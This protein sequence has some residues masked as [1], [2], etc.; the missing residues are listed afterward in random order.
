[1]VRNFS[2][3]FLLF[4]LAAAVAGC[5]E[6]QKLLKSKD[7]QRMYDK[8][9]EYYEAGKYQKSAQLLQDVAPYFIGTM[10]GDS[11][12]YYMAASYYKSG[13]FETSAMLLDE[14]RHT[15]GSSPFL[16]DAE[17]MYAKG[18]YYLSPS[19]NRDQAATRRALIAIDEYMERYPNSVKREVLE[20]DIAELQQKLYD[21]AYINA[22]TYYKIGRYKAAVVALKNALNQ[23]PDSNHREEIMYLITKSNYLL[24]HNSI[25]S[26]QRD[27]YLDM[28][29]NY[30]NFVSEFPDSK[31]IKELDKMQETAKDY[32]ANYQN[33]D[34]DEDMDDLNDILNRLNVD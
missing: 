17:Y 33:I 23:F 5:S 15:Y 12:A 22:R 32:I 9:L 29:D 13:D 28:M 2:R 6:Y 16:E 7:Y 31:Y 27:R 19:P 18:F 1:M 11:V 30:Y 20:M 21:K 14:F 24:A 25:V 10:K 3:I 8:A 4:A 34:E 26:L